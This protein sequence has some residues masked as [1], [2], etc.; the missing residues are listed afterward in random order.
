MKF[1]GF[2]VSDA[3]SGQTLEITTSGINNNLTGLT[4]NQF[5]YL[6]DTPGTIG[7]SAGTNEKKIGIAISATSLLIKNDN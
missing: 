3:L 1:I 6:N 4:P 2:A 5:Y 7:T